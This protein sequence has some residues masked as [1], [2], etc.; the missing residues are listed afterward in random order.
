MTH[1]QSYNVNNKTRATL[2]IHF[3]LYWTCKTSNGTEHS[4][5][6]E[7]SPLVLHCHVGVSQELWLEFLMH[8]EWPATTAANKNEKY[9]SVMSVWNVDKRSKYTYVHPLASA[10]EW[11]QWWQPSSTRSRMSLYRN[12]STARATTLWSSSWKMESACLVCPHIN[13]DICCFLVLL[14]V[15][16]HHYSGWFII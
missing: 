14:L 1:P 12:K 2:S 8:T 16:L 15:L 7:A 13:H 5:R 6:I 11:L 9:V 4:R 10:L 3:P